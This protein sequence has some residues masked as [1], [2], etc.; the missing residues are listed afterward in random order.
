MIR[1]MIDLYNIA[2]LVLYAVKGAFFWKYCDTVLQSRDRRYEFI[3]TEV[4]YLV[5]SGMMASVP[6]EQYVLYFAVINFFC[7]LSTLWCEI[8][9]SGVSCPADRGSADAGGIS[10]FLFLHAVCAGAGSGGAAVSVSRQ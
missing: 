4:L 9:H 2:C 8:L 10:G 1:E 5:M 3:V 7:I 6:L